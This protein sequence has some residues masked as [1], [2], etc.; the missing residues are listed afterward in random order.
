MM[1]APARVQEVISLLSHVDEPLQA[2]VAVASKEP[3]PQIGLALIEAALGTFT[4]RPHAR[5]LQTLARH[6]RTLAKRPDAGETTTRVAAIA[7][8]AAEWLAA[9]LLEALGQHERAAAILQSM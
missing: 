7:G 6:A 3:D 2:A 5:L 8:P 9:M 1:S 4:A